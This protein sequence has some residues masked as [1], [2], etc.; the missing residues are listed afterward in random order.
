MH[1]CDP[2]EIIGDD[3]APESVFKKGKLGNL[4]AA[5]K[6]GVGIDNVDFDAAQNLGIP[7][8]NTPGMFG[9]EVSDLGFVIIMFFFIIFL[10]NLIM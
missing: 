10:S 1:L 3:P 2:G 5:V 6:W 4:K 9:K 8:V 7:I